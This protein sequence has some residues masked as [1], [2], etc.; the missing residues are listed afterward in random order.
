[1]MR[2]LAVIAALVAGIFAFFRAGKE[3]ASASEAV[4][5]GSDTVD[6]AL[7]AKRQLMRELGRKGGK[8]SA[9]ARRKKKAAKEAK[10][11]EASSD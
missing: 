6:E 10:E 1:M 4:S 2:S 8:A 11:T 3:P 7:E 9:A 5:G